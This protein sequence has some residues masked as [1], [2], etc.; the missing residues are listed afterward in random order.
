MTSRRTSLGRS[1]IL[2]VLLTGGSATGFAV[3]TVEYLSTVR[4]A[5]YRLEPNEFG[6]A[7]ENIA[8]GYQVLDR[9]L[10]G[11]HSVL[12]EAETDA[13]DTVAV[14]WALFDAACA[15]DQGYEQGSYVVEDRHGYLLQFL[16]GNHGTYGRISTHLK[17]PSR[18][19]QAGHY[20]ID[21]LGD[22]QAG[23]GSW[24]PYAAS[25]PAF[26]QQNILPARKGTILFIPMAADPS[27]GL[28]TQHIFIKTEDHGMRTWSGYLHHGW[29]LVAGRVG[30]L[31]GLQTEEVARKERIDD[32][33]A[34]AWAEVQVRV[35]RNEATRLS[36]NAHKIGVRVMVAEA[37]RLQGKD[38]ELDLAIH[39]F[40]GLVASRNYDFL[41]VRTGDE[42]IFSEID[43]RQAMVPHLQARGRLLP[44][45]DGDA[46]MMDFDASSPSLP[47]PA[48]E[49]PKGLL[50]RMTSWLW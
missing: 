40:Q 38:P 11:C 14:M 42:V 2:A 20:G 36:R 43:L 16:K 49:Q 34:A 10:D 31:L 21:V 28:H 17:E 1:L 35:P 5:S 12:G 6:F 23:E 22:Y 25:N 15:K 19:T 29:D 41:D 4:N 3:D 30:K 48:P 32:H 13:T 47:A 8:R 50:D 44:A 26:V 18:L 37:R 7:R 33:L 45:A 39:N 27:I 24:R 9:V 46:W